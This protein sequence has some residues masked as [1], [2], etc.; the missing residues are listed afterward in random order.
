[1]K[2][3]TTKINIMKQEE[4]VFEVLAEG[5]SFSII[6]T[7][8][9]TGYK[10]HY[11]HNELDPTEEGLDIAEKRE[12]DRFD[13]PFRSI[14][15]KYNWY[16]LHLETIHPDYKTYVTDKLIEKLNKS[17]SVPEDIQRTINN[18]EEKLGIKLVYGNR[19]LSNGMMDIEIQFY[20]GTT[21]VHEYALTSSEYYADSVRGDELKL[22][23]EIEG[24]DWKIIKTKGKI[25]ID[26]P[27]ISIT[28]E[29]GAIK[30]VFSS[31]KAFIKAEPAK[32]M[33]MGWTYEV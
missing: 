29:S 6:K 2:S 15:Q 21:T 14:H 4:T 11:E 17:H 3:Q 8:S 33:G 23:R 24:L 30:Y 1:M 12:Y 27:T 26:G 32:G 18:L 22:Y 5:G 28:D 20:N 9:E 31:E 16:K 13:I 25:Q 10:F 19:P 7:K